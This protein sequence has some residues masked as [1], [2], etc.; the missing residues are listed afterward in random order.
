MRAA[1]NIDILSRMERNAPQFPMKHAMNKLRQ[2]SEWGYGCYTWILFSLVL[3][4]F[5]SL[6]ILLH[7]PSYGRPIARSAARMLFRL[8]RM[9]IAAKGIDRLPDQPHILLV[10]HT[11]FLDP[12]ALTALLPV[13]PGYAFAVRQQYPS[14]SLLWPL[15]KTLGTVNLKRHSTPQHHSSNIELLKAVLRRGDNLV[16]FPEGGFT[17]NAGLHPFHSGAFVV[18]AAENV[19]IVIAGLRGA[20]TALRLG[21]W[22]P[23]RTAITLE[24]GPVFMPNGK[25]APSLQQLSEAAH[26]A[27]LPLTGENDSAA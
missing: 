16:I 7:K 19:P 4:F 27:M 10:N 15:L 12:L 11:S 21:T 23:H 24:I 26:E 8:A 13:R 18:A 25:D 3:L 22:L 6:I 17:P 5:G 2:A 9:P 14:Q 20:R 1:T